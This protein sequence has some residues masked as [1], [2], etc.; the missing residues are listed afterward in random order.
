MKKKHE[1][2]KKSKPEKGSDLLP[3]IPTI[4]IG[5]NIGRAID[6]SLNTPSDSPVPSINDQNK[7]SSIGQSG[8]ITA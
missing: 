1:E 3:I 2:S 5:K 4:E 7:P 6:P 8:D